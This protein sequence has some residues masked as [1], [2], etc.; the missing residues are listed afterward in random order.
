MGLE[1]NLEHIWRRYRILN[2]ALFRDFIEGS[3][4]K[5]VAI[6]F[7]CSFQPEQVYM[8]ISTRR[9]YKCK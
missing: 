6:G 2:S 7:M 1:A 8:K 5:F 3:A 4:G 9:L